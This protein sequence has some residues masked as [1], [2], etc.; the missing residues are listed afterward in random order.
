V[1]FD[2]STFLVVWQDEYRERY[3]SNIYAAQVTPGGSVLDWFPVITQP[4]NQWYP[5]IVC[6]PGRQVMVAWEGWTEEYLGHSYNG[7]RTWGKICS[8]GAV[9]EDGL[10]QNAHDLRL[11]VVPNPSRG[12]VELGVAGIGLRSPD[13]E[14]RIYDASGR[15]V[16][17]LRPE[18]GG[19][20]STT[21]NGTDNDGKAL[22]AGV[23]L[24]KLVTQDRPPEMRQIILLR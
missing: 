17:R 13:A 20:R 15:M 24:V 6:G 7:N 8:F 23:Y 1:A 9:A 5:T 19:Q 12:H 10:A 3:C 11:A 4:G 14:L 2:G 18:A 22:P 16:R 21:W